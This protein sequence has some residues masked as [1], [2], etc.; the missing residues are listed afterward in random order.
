MHLVGAF[1]RPISVCNKPSLLD[2]DNS[3]TGLK[4]KMS[5]DEINKAIAEFLGWTRFENNTPSDDY[6]PKTR[7]WFFPAGKHGQFKYAK[8]ADGLP[9]YTEDLNAC[10]AMESQLET[11]DRMKFASELYRL[12]GHPVEGGNSW[13]LL[14]ATARQR[15]EALL[16]TINKWKE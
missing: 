13:Y 12:S 3:H 6:G 11:E 1:H 14:H 2:L 16:R 9:N 5:D 7:E 15:C 10:H 4:G 8:S